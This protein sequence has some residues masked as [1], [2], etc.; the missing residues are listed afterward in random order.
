MAIFIAKNEIIP[1]LTTRWRTKKILKNRAVI[2]HWS[3]EEK[4]C[5]CQLTM[6]NASTISQSNQLFLEFESVRA[7]RS[8]KNMF[9]RGIVL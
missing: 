7:H 4:K 3:N 8:A 1:S 9:E 5:C 2:E 6:E